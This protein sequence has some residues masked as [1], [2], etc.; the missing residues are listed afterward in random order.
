MRK[1]DY[2]NKGYLIAG[3]IISFIIFLFGLINA[4]EGFRGVTIAL[5]EDIYSSVNSDISNVESFFLAF[6]NVGEVRDENKELRIQLQELESELTEARNTLDSVGFIVEKG[7]VDFDEEYNSIPVRVLAYDQ[8]KSGIIYL[9]KGSSDGIDKENIVVL[10]NSAVGEVI[11]VFANYS[12]VRVIA[13]GSYTLNVVSLEN[14]ER[15]ILAGNLGNEIIVEQ[16][17]TDA[18]LEEGDVFVTEG[19]DKKYPYGLF[20]GRVSSINSNPADPLK[21][22]ILDNSIDFRNLDRLY[23]IQVK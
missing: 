14:N 4:F 8:E 18:I 13:S 16:I 2:F 3:S 12:S 22:A 17:L 20:V 5:M 1:E 23:V 10:G 19:K 9:N 11:D 7:I 21:S 6:D 15:G